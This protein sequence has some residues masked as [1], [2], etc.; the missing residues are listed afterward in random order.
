MNGDETET[1]IY[2]MLGVPQSQ[3]PES[4]KRKSGGEKKVQ[5]IVK[6]LLKKYNPKLYQKLLEYERK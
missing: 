1:Y 6:T 3:R 4:G 2:D 5:K